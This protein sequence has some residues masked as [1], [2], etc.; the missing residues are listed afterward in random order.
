MGWIFFLEICPFLFM[1]IGH[2]TFNRESWWWVY[3]ALVLGL[4]PSPTT[5][6]QKKQLID[7]FA[8]MLI[9]LVNILGWF[10]FTLHWPW[11]V[12]CHFAK[13]NTLDGELVKTTFWCLM[14]VECLRSVY[15]FYSRDFWLNHRHEA[16]VE[17]GILDLS[18][19]YL[20]KTDFPNNWLE[21]D[22]HLLKD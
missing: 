22:S 15:P 13:Q 3:K 14:L 5:G 4:W 12:K 16:L 7:P 9:K 10:S 18:H 2:A 8:H 20:Q 21:H 19:L 1:D 6:I 11:K 17:F